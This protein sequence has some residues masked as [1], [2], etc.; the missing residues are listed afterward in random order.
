MLHAFI[1]AFFESFSSAAASANQ[2]TRTSRRCR[3]GSRGAP[4][5]FSRRYLTF[6]SLQLEIFT[7]L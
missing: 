3:K 4:P 7:R 5:N 2:E 1:V 6:E